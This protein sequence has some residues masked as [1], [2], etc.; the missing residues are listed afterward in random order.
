MENRSFGL[1]PVSFWGF[2]CFYNWLAARQAL[3]VS[4]MVPLNNIL[5]LNYST[6]LF[7]DLTT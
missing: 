1:G 7:A 2:C 5:V 6:P 4:N 3:K